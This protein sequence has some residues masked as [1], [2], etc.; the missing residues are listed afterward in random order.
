MLYRLV[1]PDLIPWHDGRHRCDDAERAC[2]VGPAGKGYGLAAASGIPIPTRA[3]FATLARL[4][5]RLQTP[6]ERGPMIDADVYHGSREDALR[7]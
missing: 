4:L 1:E 3:E 6:E 7:R 2:G 5:A